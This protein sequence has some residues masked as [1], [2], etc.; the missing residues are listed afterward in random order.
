MKY[1]QLPMHI[2]ISI[3]EFGVLSEEKKV[4]KVVQ[5]ESW[6]PHNVIFDENGE[7]NF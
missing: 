6:T 1:D 5:E 4:E 7:P 3:R 2:E